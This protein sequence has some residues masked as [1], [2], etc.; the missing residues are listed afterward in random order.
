MTVKEKKL[1]WLW[2][3]QSQN[4]FLTYES[5]KDVHWLV[6]YCVIIVPIVIMVVNPSDFALSGLGSVPSKSHDVLVL[7]VTL[8]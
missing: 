6:Q 7:L 3:L 8:Q 1:Q 5:R 4:T 2:Q